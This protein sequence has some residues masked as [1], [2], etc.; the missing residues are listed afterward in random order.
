[1]PG[2]LNTLILRVKIQLLEGLFEEILRPPVWAEQKEQYDGLLMSAKVPGGTGVVC[3]LSIC[4][5]WVMEER[6][7]CF[8]PFSSLLWFHFDYCF[9]L[10]LVEP[11]QAQWA[12]MSLL[13]KALGDSFGRVHEN[14]GNISKK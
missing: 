9:F 1:M 7:H 11:H 10:F 2:M 3:M 14:T 5:F 13:P 8:T 6:L 4:Y 12:P